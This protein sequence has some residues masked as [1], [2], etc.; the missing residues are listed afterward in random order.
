VPE[1]IKGKTLI[2]ADE[3]DIVNGVV[4][5]LYGEETNG[6]ISIIEQPW[7]STPLSTRARERRLAPRARRRDARPGRQR[8]RQGD[9]W[10]LGHE[11]SSHP[12]HN[13]ERGIQTGTHHGAVHARWVRA[14]LQGFGD[15][16]REGPI[17]LDELNRL[18]A[19]HG[20]RFVNDWIPELKSTY[21][22]RVIGE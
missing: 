7:L 18:G 11:A 3:G 9:G 13:V 22:V 20:I 10:L 17:G 8:D 4:I 14:L 19:P 6:A 16:L 21:N 5:K 1:R 15:R 2:A 12:P